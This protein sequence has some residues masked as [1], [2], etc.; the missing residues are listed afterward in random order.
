MAAPVRITYRTPIVRWWL[1]GCFS[2]LMALGVL[3]AFALIASGKSVASTTQGFGILGL[4]IFTIVGSRR[5]LVIDRDLGVIR[6]TR[7]L[8]RGDREVH[9]LVDGLTGVEVERSG[10][11]ARLILVYGA[12]RR[13]LTQDFYYG[14]AH[15]HDVAE[16]VRR[17]LG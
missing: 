17:A 10:E 11:R 16:K 8:R 12:Q 5:K 15:H 1:A 6:L 3:S 4:L 7:G 9:H 13:P 2:V 14:L